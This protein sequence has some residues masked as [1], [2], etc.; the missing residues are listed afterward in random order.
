[1]VN[2]MKPLEEKG[3]CV[4]SKKDLESLIEDQFRLEALENFGVDNWDGYSEAMQMANERF[5]EEGD[6]TVRCYFKNIKM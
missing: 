6:K 1:M 5:N 2:K 4:I 3:Y